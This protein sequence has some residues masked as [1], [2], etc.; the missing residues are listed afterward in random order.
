MIDSIQY[1]PNGPFRPEEIQLLFQSAGF[2]VQPLSRLVGAISGSTVY[3]TA[4]DGEKLVGFGR[5]LTDHHSIA[6]INYMAVAPGYRRKGIGQSI[7][8]KLLEASGDVDRVFLYTDTADIF[9]QRNGFVPS[10]KRLYL[11]RKQGTAPPNHP[12]AS[13]GPVKPFS[14]TGF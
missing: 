6:Y 2:D 7:L 13:F 12:D 10:E 8:R 11:Y 9:Y 5:L 1:T 3:I 4:T 14:D